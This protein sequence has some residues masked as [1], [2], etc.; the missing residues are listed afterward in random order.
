MINEEKVI[1]CLRKQ[2]KLDN[3]KLIKKNKTTVLRLKMFMEIVSGFIGTIQSF[4]II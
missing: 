4:F 1:K 2:L 3:S